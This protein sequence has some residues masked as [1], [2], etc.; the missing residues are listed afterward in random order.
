MLNQVLLGTHFIEG[1]ICHV[2]IAL[3]KRKRVDIDFVSSIRLERPIM[4]CLTVDGIAKAATRAVWYNTIIQCNHKRIIK[5]VPA[6]LKF[7][8]S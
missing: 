6:M 4:S 8:R 1:T 2:I 3:R 7:T 5:S